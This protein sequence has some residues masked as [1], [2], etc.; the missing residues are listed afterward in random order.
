MKIKKLAGVL[1]LAIAMA[2][3][4]RVFVFETV[5]VATSA[6]SENQPIGNRLIIEKWTLGARLPLSISAPFT[7]DT[8]FGKPAFFRV[9]NRAFRLPG[10]HK[11]KRNDILAFNY[12]A[13]DNRPID[14]LPIL[15]S[16]C[17]GLPGEFIRLKGSRIFINEV[18]MERHPDVSF[19]Y[20][21]PIRLQ[22]N[23]IRE[24]GLEHIDRETFQEKDSA[25]IYLTRYQYYALAR[26]YT[27][28]SINLS[29]YST[30]LED[31]SAVIP[32][33]GYRIKLNDRSYL[34]WGDIINRFEGVRLKHMA[35]GTFI[36]E[37]QVTEYYTFK[38][39]YYWLLNDHQGYMNDS[40]RLGLIPESYI[41]GKAC[42]VFFSPKEKR[43]LQKI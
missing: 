16:R 28:G 15:L 32:Y 27:N 29:A 19:C 43:F 21:Y 4:I 17:V 12:Q 35:D 33:E 9:S 7:P 3:V 8:L 38:Q 13:K 26:R 30:A 11:I 5:R 1:F 41:I 31:K 39:N 25:Y 24:L 40:R 22:E 10:F 14:L 18:E 34:L 6:L 20:R 36:E 2:L 37:D 23:V 42:L